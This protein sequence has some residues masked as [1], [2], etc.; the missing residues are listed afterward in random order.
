MH[1]YIHQIEQVSQA[2]FVGFFGPIGVGA[3]FYLSVCRQFLLEEMIV[4]GEVRPDAAR[5]AEVTYIVVWFLVICSIFVHGLSVPLGKAGYHIPRT[6]STALSSA[7]ADQEA[8]RLPSSLNTHS[9][10][11]AESRRGL[12][13]YR[14]RGKAPN[15]REPPRIVF[16][17]AGSQQRREEQ[18]ED[19]QVQ[20]QRQDAEVAAAANASADETLSP[21]TT[22]PSVPTPVTIHEP[23]RPIRLMGDDGRVTETL[24]GDS[25]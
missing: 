9:T 16:Q 5:T 15:P 20:Q 10:A 24:N 17:I 23:R 14:K 21:Q 2:L 11:T 6:I 3:I 19:Q 25:E 22:M 8:I 7:S 13:F 1:K 12:H 4:D 18:Q